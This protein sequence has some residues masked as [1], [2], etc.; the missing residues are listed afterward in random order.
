MQKVNITDWYR[1]IRLQ[2]KCEAVR[3]QANKEFIKDTFSPECNRAISHGVA[4]QKAVA[5]QRHSMG[6]QKTMDING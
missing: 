3:V 2:V 1:L 6:L 4:L 5:Y